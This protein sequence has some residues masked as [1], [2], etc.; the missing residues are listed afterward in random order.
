MVSNTGI[1]ETVKHR[2]D[3]LSDGDAAAVLEFIDY[4][5]WRKNQTDS[6]WFWQDEWQTRYQDAKADLEAGRYQDF[7][8]A[9][10]LLAHLK[11]SDG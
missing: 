9:D 11:H 2:L 1:K 7:D 3:E 4:L 6:A 10:D 5:R 8:N